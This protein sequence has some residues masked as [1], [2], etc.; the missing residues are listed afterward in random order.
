MAD[1]YIDMDDDAWVKEPKSPKPV[2]CWFCGLVGLN[3]QMVGDNWLLFKGDKLHE[4]KG[5]KKSTV[6]VEDAWIY[7][8]DTR[9]TKR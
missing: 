6:T 4:C 9:P 5:K 7:G 3:W 8:L 1:Y 2:T